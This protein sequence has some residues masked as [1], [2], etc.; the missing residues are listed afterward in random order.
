MPST[1]TA[2][3]VVIETNYI[4]VTIRN[5]TKPTA[6]QTSST[7]KYNK[8]PASSADFYTHISGSRTEYPFSGAILVVHKTIINKMCL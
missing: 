2:K 7:E 5:Q 3:G 4:F 8:L 6:D 1:D